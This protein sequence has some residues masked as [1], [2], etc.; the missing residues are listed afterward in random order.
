MDF[1][2]IVSKARFKHY[3]KRVDRDYVKAERLYNFNIAL[4]GAFYQFLGTFE[5]IIRNTID[6]AL[7]K[8]NSDKSG[9][10][11]WFNKPAGELAKTVNKIRVH[12]NL[13][14]LSIDDAIPKITF[15][16]WPYF[17]PTKGIGFKKDLWDEY[18][19]NEFLFWRQ[20]PLLLLKV[21][22]KIINFRNRV[23]HLE[24]IYNKKFMYVRHMCYEICKTQTNG[25]S[26]RNHLYKN[27][28]I[29][30]VIKRQDPAETGPSVNPAGLPTRGHNITAMNYKN[31]IAQK[32][33]QKQAKDEAFSDIS[34]QE[35]EIEGVFVGNIKIAKDERGEVRKFFDKSFFEKFGINF[36][37]KNFVLLN[38][39]T[40]AGIKRGTNIRPPFYSKLAYLKS[41]RV[42][43]KI[44]DM[45]DKSNSYQKK[46]QFV[47]EGS[48]GFLVYIP[49][50]VIW[51]TLTIN[52]SEHV[53]IEESR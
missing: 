25:K 10:E 51:E 28:F 8:Y 52:D 43:Y 24:P 39:I 3:L 20:S 46:I 38:T 30:N 49:E 48:E 37:P 21:L 1:E 44:R 47:T 33:D 34:L 6:K 41:G 16:S 17:L 15:G 9:D 35:T 27:D 2:E 53:F 32:K 5:V 42:K 7:R 45:R 26:K 29:N 19:S 18:L 11:D 50:G 31:I 12:L 36:N 13:K 4:S 40:K 22:K 23:A 14:N